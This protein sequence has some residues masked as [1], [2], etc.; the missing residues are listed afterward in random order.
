MIA[1]LVLLAVA[2]GSWLLRV[3]FVTF[4]DVETMPASVRGVLDY[5]GPAVTAALV[6]TA[7]ADG[8]GHTGLRLSLP[9]VAGLLGATVIAVRTRSLLSALLVAMGMFAAVR[10]LIS[11]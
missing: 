3:A 7:L 4:V 8:E 9:E 6:V 5:V 10:L 1:T 2:A 11:L